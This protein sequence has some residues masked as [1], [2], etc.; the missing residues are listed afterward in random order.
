MAE[1]SSA[2]A[3]VRIEAVSCFDSPDTLVMHNLATGLSERLAW[4]FRPGLEFGLSRLSYDGRYLA[5]TTLWTDE[6]DKSRIRVWDL[7]ERVPMGTYGRF[8]LSAHS[9]GFSPD[10]KRLV[11][12]SAGKEAVKIWDFESRQELLTLSANGGPF[13]P[14]QFKD[15][16]TL[17][18]NARG[19][20]HPWRAPSREEIAAAEAKDKPAPQQP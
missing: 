16:G 2:T 19:A 12:G 8:I 5:A 6:A 7:K 10:G 3:H 20:E 13:S 18:G 9:V 4:K 11:A 15:A 14:V 1:G 17:V